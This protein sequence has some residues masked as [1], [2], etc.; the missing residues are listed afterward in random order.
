MKR[1]EFRANDSRGEGNADMWGRKFQ[2]EG[3]AT[4][5]VRGPKT[6]RVPGANVYFPADAEQ[7]E[8]LQSATIEGVWSNAD[9]K[10]GV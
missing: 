9:R 10:G 1:F 7:K 5:N 4:A 6:R 3:L 8:E 2:I